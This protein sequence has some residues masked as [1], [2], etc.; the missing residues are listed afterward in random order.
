MYSQ[1]T[2]KTITSWLTVGQ[3]I[4]NVNVALIILIKGNFEVNYL[5]VNI[6]KDI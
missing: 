3:L 5:Y 2:G 6:N 4:G 1:I